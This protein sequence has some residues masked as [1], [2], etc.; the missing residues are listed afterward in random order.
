MKILLDRLWLRDPC[1]FDSS[2][3]AL[4]EHAGADAVLHALDAMLAEALGQRRWK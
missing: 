1:G 2:M 4:I 3:D